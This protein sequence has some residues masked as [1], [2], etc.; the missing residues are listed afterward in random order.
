M[1]QRRG[2]LRFFAA[3]LALVTALALPGLVLAQSSSGNLEGRVMDAQGAVLP[4]VTVV[5]TNAAT[6]LAR[7][8]VTGSDGLYRFSA[9]PAGNY[10]VTYELEGFSRASS[11]GVVVNVAATLRADVTLQVA[12]VEESITVT[13]E[14]PLVQTTPSIGTVVSQKELENLPLNGRQFANLAVLAPGTTLAYNSDPTKPGQ[15]T[16]QLAGGNGRNVNFIMD[17]GDNTDDTIGGALQNFN[18]EAVQEFNIQTMQYKAEYG[19]SSGGV[20]TVVTKTGG[21]EFS[22]SAYGYFRDKSLNSKTE[23]EKLAGISKQDYKRKQYGAS[24]GGPIVKDKAH[25]FVTYEKTKRD[26]NYTVFT[27]G[28]FPTFDGTVVATP[29]T[30]ELITAKGTLDLNA[31]QYLQVRYGYQKNADKYG[32]SPLAAPDGLGTV[33]NK[34]KSYLFGHTAQ[35]GDGALN[36]FVFQYTKFNNAITADSQ[37]PLIYYPSGFHTGQNLNTPQTTNQEKYQYKDD[38]GWTMDLGGQRHDFKVGAAYLHEPTLGGDF[39]TGKA[40]QFTALEDR[41]GSPISLIQIYGGFFVNSTPVDQTSGFLQDDW[42]VNSHLTLN[43]G[44]RYDYFDFY[45]QLNQS[46]NPIFNRLRSQRTYT[47]AY[48]KDFWGASDTLS[49]DS[50]NFAPRLGFT[51]DVG[52]D[53]K[54]IVRGGYGTFYDFPYSNATLLFP[55]AAV[56]SRYGLVYENADPN[57]IKNADGSTY[58]PGVDPLPP[59]QTTPDLGGPDEVASPTLATPYSDQISLGYSWQVNDWLGLNFEAVSIDFHDI[60]FRFRPNVGVDANGDHV[61]DPSSGETRRFSEFG[62]FRVWNG[63]GRTNYDGVNIGFHLRKKS[64]QMQGFYTYSKAEG[65]V[66]GGADEF[67]LTPGEYQSDIGGSR[68]RRDQSVNPLDPWCDACFGP[69]Y[70]DSKHRLTLGGV[71]TGPWGINVSGM[72]RFRSGLPYLE[73]ANA[74]LNGDGSNID[75]RPGVKNVNSGRGESFKQL[76]IRVSK[77]FAFGNGMGVEVLAEMFNVTNSKNGARPSRFGVSSAFAGDPGQGEQQL[78]QLGARFHF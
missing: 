70:T 78:L 34:Y 53:G 41:I 64:F 11:E 8:T 63:S 45:S 56:Q 16:I 19:R 7:T 25:F 33:T 32:A 48:L 26:T 37:S 21:N 28:A 4:G 22:G 52:G 61:F 36:E 62:N 15:L 5:A 67:R 42:Y 60:P 31:K 57:G 13:T 46:S 18:L 24:L 27:A 10:N 73:H 65:N 55:S 17:G 12:S 14:A 58:R 43:L 68:Q 59:N 39:S 54:H 51:W 2:Y 50:D 74:D 38:F 3:A 47:E 66:L 44:V 1:Q 72:F 30:D 71:W 6:G 76:D 35:I 77:D 23:S 75:L 69:L 40:G 20:L 49:N 29:F 9:L